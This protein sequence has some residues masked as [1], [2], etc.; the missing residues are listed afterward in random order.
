ML[1]FHLVTNQVLTQMMASQEFPTTR[2]WHSFIAWKIAPNALSK[3]ST[4]GQQP[5][6]QSLPISQF[7]LM[8]YSTTTKRNSVK[9]QSTGTDG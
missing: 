2:E 4:L 3:N 7:K 1:L 6:A 9:D 8:I 5:T